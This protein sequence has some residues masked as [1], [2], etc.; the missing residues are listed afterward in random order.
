MKKKDAIPTN[1]FTN[2][3]LFKS[4]TSLNK[5]SID[6]RLQNIQTYT[7]YSIVLPFVVVYRCKSDTNAVVNIT[8]DYPVNIKS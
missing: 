3:S 5:C 7:N 6:R 2:V 4:C 1:R 8:G